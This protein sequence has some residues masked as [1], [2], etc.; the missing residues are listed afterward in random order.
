MKPQRISLIIL[1]AFLIACATFTTNSYRSLVVSAETYETAMKSIAELYKEGHV[2]DDV[3]DKAI[4]LGTIYWSAYHTA[5]DGLAAYQKGEAT[6][7]EITT[8]LAIVSATLGSFLEYVRPV[9]IQYDK[10]I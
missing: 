7:D 8:Q 4:E 1:L 6:K 2:G 5:A 3:K 10:E 9:L